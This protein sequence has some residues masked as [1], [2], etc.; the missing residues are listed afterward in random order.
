MTRPTSRE[1]K[2]M[3]TSVVTEDDDTH[4][5]EDD[6]ARHASDDHAP[7]TVQAE[8]K[9]E[10]E[11]NRRNLVNIRFVELEA[12]L[13]RSAPRTDSA[14]R[15][16]DFA[17]Q[18]VTC[19]NKGK[20]IDKEAVLKDAANRIAVQRKD[21]E[22][23]AARMKDMSTEIDNLRSEK[24]ELRSDKNY[25][26]SE[27]ETVRKEVQR[28]REDNINLWQAF[29]KASTLKDSLASDIAKIPAEL[30][31]R[32]A[33]APPDQLASSMS[34]GDAMVQPALSMPMTQMMPRQGSAPVPQQSKSMQ[35][36]A[37]QGFSPQQVLAQHMQQPNAAL[38]TSAA[39][40]SNAN[41]PIQHVP[42]TS[43]SAALS[44]SFLVCTGPDEIGEL[45]ANYVPGLLQSLGPS[46]PTQNDIPGD[47]AENTAK[48]V[49]DP[50]PVG[51]IQQPSVPASF[52]QLPTVQQ[53]DAS[54]APQP[55]SKSESELDPFSDVA[56]CV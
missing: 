10:L 30:F 52:Q 25:L 56:Y 46:T 5:S 42:S 31:L 21:L 3:R 15:L 23:A 53:A 50:I 14:G 54:D 6:H 35:P 18:E 48:N 13:H 7:R 16:H 43:A 33:N 17:D 40:P 26:R 2:R 27:L 36:S 12:E 51:S 41:Q 55:S 19:P 44:D 45:F 49:Q 22:N 28:L 38:R 39:L 4:H 24:V 8:R 11:R 20:R 47:I 29:R 37:S 9:R 1:K 34:A 32:R